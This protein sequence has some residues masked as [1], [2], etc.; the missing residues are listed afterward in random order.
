MSAAGNHPF[1]LLIN[2]DSC[3]HCRRCPAGE[4]CRGGAFVKF[5]PDD[6]P[7]IDM[8]R[9]WGCLACVVACPFEAIVRVEYG[10]QESPVR[11]G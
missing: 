11:D 1:K 2:E 4:V 10:P 9:C 8:S 7:F 5:E 3:Q 6:S